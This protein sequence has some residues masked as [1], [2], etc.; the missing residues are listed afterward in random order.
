[1]LTN[2]FCGFLLLAISL[3]YWPR[4]E[5]DSQKIEWSR[6][7]KK[8]AYLNFIQDW[9]RVVVSGCRRFVGK[10]LSRNENTETGGRTILVRAHRF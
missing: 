2:Y 4:F 8:N 3:S 1:M 7:E 5:N 10:Y 6:K 9:N